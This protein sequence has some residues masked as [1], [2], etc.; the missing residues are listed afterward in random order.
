MAGSSYLL[1]TTQVAAGVDGATPEK[2]VLVTYPN[3][4]HIRFDND[5][6]T[7]ANPPV[8]PLAEIPPRPP[9]VKGGWGDL[10][11]KVGLGG[12]RP[13]GGLSEQHCT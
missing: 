3:T 10:F 1:C 5:A 13:A 2:Q 12:F 11:A 7:R 6:R 4:V 9:L 8:P